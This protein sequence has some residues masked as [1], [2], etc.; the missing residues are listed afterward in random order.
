MGSN[1]YIAVHDSEIFKLV[2]A[3]VTSFSA[4]YTLYSVGA[5]S[6]PILQQLW[7]EGKWNNK[8]V[9]E[10][11]ILV[12]FISNLAFASTCCK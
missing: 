12:R 3:P 8:R 11:L 4:P 1:Q 2:T 10:R 7:L 6:S 5:K 9:I